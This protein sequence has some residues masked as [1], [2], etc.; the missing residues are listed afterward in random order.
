MKTILIILCVIFHFTAA[1]A[2]TALNQT[3]SNHLKQGKWIGKYPDG[4]VRYDGS[5][6]N[7]K[8]MGE[9]KRFHENG[10]LKATLLH[11]LNSDKVKAELF[12]SEGLLVAKGNFIGT[13][14][15]SVWTYYD[16]KAI[17]ARENYNNGMKN[18]KSFSYS[19]DGKTLSE[20]D[21]VNGRL[22][23]L[24]R[25]FYIEGNKKSETRYLD[26][27]RQGDSNIYFETGKVQI[28][29]SYNNDR[30]TGRWKFYNPDGSL[31]FQLDYK[32]GIMQNP[33]ALD[34]LQLKE[35]KAFDETKGKL[36]DPERY[37]ENPE[38]YLRK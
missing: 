7:D 37:R 22:N 5:F 10:K 14:K 36:K 28:E 2:Q 9:W 8:P 6:I 17:I 33:E 15:D 11:A 19:A 16:N 1:T 12:D 24:E 31:K 4:T 13:L 27:K 25:E 32:D 23:G 35:F 38:E 18:G 21:W 26:G 3:D 20:T 30:Y 29:G 34:S